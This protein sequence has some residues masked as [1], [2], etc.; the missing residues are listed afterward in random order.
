M[1]S[2]LLQEL[3][4]LDKRQSF[5]TSA[6]LKKGSTLFPQGC[7]EGVGPPAL[8]EGGAHKLFP[9]QRGRSGGHGPCCWGPSVEGVREV[10]GAWFLKC[11]DWK[12]T[13]QKGLNH[14]SF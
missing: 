14:C 9:L 11:L 2:Q 6:S 8:V 3:C 1:G 7:E 5:G 4:N 10:T 12:G 13:K